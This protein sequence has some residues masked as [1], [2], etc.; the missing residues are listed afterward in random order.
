MDATLAL[1]L[2][3]GL[4]G[5]R[6]AGD[7]LYLSIDKDGVAVVTDYPRAEAVDYQPGDFERIALRQKG[8]AHRGLGARARGSDRPAALA[9]GIPPWIDELVSTASRKHELPPSLLVA[10]IAVESGFRADAVSPAGAVG[11]MQ[12]M[13]ATAAELGVGDALDPQQNIDAGA[14]Y[15]AFLR[16]HFKSDELALAAYN[17]GPGRVA[18]AGGVPDI[19]ETKAY[20]ESVLGLAASYEASTASR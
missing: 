11:L 2:V 7:R 4:H 20:I 6:A 8:V 15:L 13:P 18:R 1:A 17:A 19:P 14:R 12:L 16:R 3:L 5:P 10:V 9:P